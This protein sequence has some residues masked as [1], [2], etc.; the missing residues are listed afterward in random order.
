VDD[1]ANNFGLGN[2]N[3]P[4]DVSGMLNLLTNRRG[5]KTPR[6]KQLEDI[7]DGV[8]ASFQQNHPR[9]R[10]NY[11]GKKGHMTDTCYQRMDDEEGKSNSSSRSERSTDSGRGWFRESPRSGVSGFQYMEKA[12]WSQED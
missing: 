1:L 9:M 11:C 4:E 8:L 7:Q 5:I 2:I 12:A 3:Y 6:S 10:C